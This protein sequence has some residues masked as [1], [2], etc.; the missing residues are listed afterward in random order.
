MI[1]THILVND[2]DQVSSQ[3]FAEVL[4]EEGFHVDQ[5]HSGEEAFAQLQRRPYDLLLTDI[6]LPGISG[7]EL[8]RKIRAVAPDLPIVVMT[9]FGSMETAIEAIREGAFDYASKPMNLGELKETIARALSLRTLPP[10]DSHQ[11]NGGPTVVPR[12][13]VIG[14]SAAMIE[15]YKTV[16]RVAST[17]SIVLILGESG[18]GKELIARAIHQHSERANG[19][20][21]ALD[22]GALVET[23]LES[24][25]FGHVRGAFTGA[26][27]DKKG[28][29]EAAHEGTC[30]I[31]EIGD[32]SP[33]LQARLLRVL[34]ENEIRRVGSQRVTKIDVRV[35]A[36][37]NKDLAALVQE[38][39]FRED[40]YYR[41]N[42]LSITLPPLRERLEDV[43]D[44]ALAFL[45]RY[46]YE[47]K[48]SLT[49]ITEEALALLQAYAWPGN[50]R[51]L[52]NVMS[53]AVVMARQSV[54]TPDDFPERLRYGKE[55]AI[56]SLSADSA[57]TDSSFSF[58]QLLSL[59]EMKKQ[60][61]LYVLKQTRGNMSRTAEV[62]Q[63]DRRSLYR[64]L[65]RF[66]VSLPSEKH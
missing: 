15:V 4:Q 65:K 17:R 13:T 44:L 12:Q 42:V 28:V 6:R 35:I 27:I 64:M 21:V 56:R 20:F 36:A 58:A 1:N 59:E 31:D 38:G 18:T 63:I 49:A 50:I 53:R 39:V 23:L 41:L 14:K 48:K 24:E 52:E 26:V 29:F 37:T 61:I 8:T 9:A 51:E 33:A 34:Q 3:L 30:F 32:I 25:L 16:A 66:A 7:L 5:T 43:P 22:C 57:S 62:L 2:D 45:H 54:L 60:Y 19:P 46:A 55:P 40:L 47:H 11:Q 10:R